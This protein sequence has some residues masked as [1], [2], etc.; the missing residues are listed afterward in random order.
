MKMFMLLLVSFNIIECK[1]LT[2]KE[3][4]GDITL[5]NIE[6]ENPL[7]DKDYNLDNSSKNFTFIDNDNDKADD[8]LEKHLIGNNNFNNL[9][10]L[11]MYQKH[12]LLK[13]FYDNCSL[14]FKKTLCLRLYASLNQ[15]E[16]RNVCRKE[17]KTLLKEAHMHMELYKKQY[18][19][20]Q[21]K[22]SIKNT[23]KG[24][25]R[26]HIVYNTKQFH[27]ILPNLSCKKGK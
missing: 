6:K 4:F 26:D 9:S 8:R 25:D 24:I 5:E 16:L 22:I 3:I 20:K 12:Y 23:V 10:K 15:Y 2:S 21:I 1:A 19:S 11:F 18:M 7:K 17:F 13:V 27:F 14:K